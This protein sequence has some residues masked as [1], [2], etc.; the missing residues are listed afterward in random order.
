L[1]G[2]LPPFL[3][4]GYRERLA[5]VLQIAREAPDH[6]V[7][8]TA[9]IVTSGGLEAWFPRKKRYDGHTYSL[10]FYIYILKIIMKI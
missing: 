1:E 6:A 9:D 3:A 8:E 7:D 4:G 2:P 5:A 10:S